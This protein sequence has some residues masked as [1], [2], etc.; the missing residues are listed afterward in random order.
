MKIVDLA[1]V[2]PTLNEEGYIGKLLG[3]IALQTVQPKEIVVVDAFSKDKT[4]DQVKKCQLSLP[5]L[6]WCQIKKDTIS[7]QRNFG[8]KKTTAKHLLFL[9][10]DGVLKNK[11]VLEKYFAE[12]E[13]K[14]P[15]LAA[16]INLPNS[17]DW[18]DWVYFI[19]ENSLIYIQTY[20]RPTSTGRNLYFK[21][22]V[23][24]KIHGFDQSI[25][26]CEDVEI[27]QRAHDHGFKF[28]L[29]STPKIYTSTR[30]LQ[31]EGHVKHIA[32]MV[33][34]FML[35]KTYGYQHNPIQAEYEFGNFS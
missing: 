27:V 28:V 9:D 18:R 17:K 3:S 5:Q 7:K 16:A 24:N 35:N 33:R 22:S 12:I 21:R 34:Y 25:A 32:K 1:I 30:R 2:I 11:L 20:L 31:K 6:K 8:A 13:S 10:A 23:F 19:G 14:K 26:L 4:I 29:L 15:D